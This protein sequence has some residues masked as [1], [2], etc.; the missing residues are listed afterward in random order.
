MIGDVSRFNMYVEPLN[1]SQVRHN[2]NVYKNKY[3]LLYWG[4]P[5]CLLLT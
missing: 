2:F 3:S 4:C 1:A 5:D